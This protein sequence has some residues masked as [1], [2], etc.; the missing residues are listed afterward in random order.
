MTEN[1]TQVVPRF[2]EI[3]L[4][5]FDADYRKAEIEHWSTLETVIPS[6]EAIADI[7]SPPGFNFFQGGR[8]TVLDIGCGIG[9]LAFL[10]AQKNPQARVT[11][12]DLSEQSI[13]YANEHYAPQAANLS[14]QV[15]SVDDLSL[16]FEDI[17]MITCVGALHHF[18]D[19]NNALTQITRVL[20]SNGAFFLSDLNRENILA[21]FSAEELRYLDR[22]RQLPE[23]ARDSRL[24][25]QGYTKGAKMRRFLTLMSFQ[26]AYTPAEVA[27]ALGP[28]Y[29]FQGK[30]AGV[31]YLLVASRKS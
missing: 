27:L 19:L 18:P 4:Q 25:R 30:M 1:R 15:G 10:L 3:P 21:H 23:K 12:V 7:G 28:D 22:V 5:E 2:P 9:T 20:S 11:G 24:R 17:D 14:F 13:A 29:Q 16:N 26:A 8:C 31:N 6:F